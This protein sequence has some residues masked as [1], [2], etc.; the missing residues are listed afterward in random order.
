MTPW[1]NLKI[2]RILRGKL[3]VNVLLLAILNY[4]NLSSFIPSTIIYPTKKETHTVAFSN[5]LE[6]NNTFS[7]FIY[8]IV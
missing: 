7:Y 5:F 2:L 8:T 1:I 4:F 3:F 6:N